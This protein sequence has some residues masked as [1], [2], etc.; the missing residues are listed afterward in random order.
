MSKYGSVAAG[1]QLTAE[2]AYEVLKSG[3]NAFDAAM[4][5][6]FMACVAEPVLASP[7]GGGFLLAKTEKEPV[8]YDFFTQTPRQKIPH[9]T[10]FYPI[11]V[12]FGT[13][14]QEFHIGLGAAAVPGV[15]EGIFKVHGELGTLPASELVKP[16]VAS[17]RNG[18]PVKGIMPYLFKIVSPIYLA[19]QEAKSLFESKESPGKVIGTGDTLK[20]TQLADFLEN[21]ALE[22]P[23]FFYRGPVANAI[24]EDCANEMGHL[25]QK[26]FDSYQVIRRKPLYN[27]YHNA[28]IW[29]NPQP[30][31]GGLLISLGLQLLQPF[32]LKQLSYGSNAYLDLLGKTMA[33]TNAV[34]K[35]S[36]EGPPDSHRDA[37]NAIDPALIK[38][39]Q[40]IQDE[41]PVNPRGTTHISIIDRESQIA[42]MTLSNGEGCGY[43]V[44]NCGFM[45]NNMLGEEDLNPAGFHLWKPN[46]RI[47]SMMAP[48]IINQR[49]RQIATGSGGSNRIRSALLQIIINCVDY[50]MSI[51][52]AVERPRVHFEHGIF[53]LESGFPTASLTHIK[54]Q[55]M[56][57]KI[58]PDSNLFFGG[59]HTVCRDQEGQFSG[60]GDPRR[61]GVCL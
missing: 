31:L 46:T 43:I 12:D 1:H 47:A 2:A 38:A 16:A 21:L 24:Y 9:G 45:L 50:E 8:L 19:S 29:T 11:E 59:A 49:N 53:N 33:I 39:L 55:Y 42:T 3:G 44:P 61:G 28:D 58:W 32:N 56:N 13:V 27:R 10:E 36:I 17:G 7:G 4:A 48:T 5:A 14:V 40:K 20:Q 26:D 54:S 51:Q 37:L 60:M 25:T 52:D 57:T 34:K 22:G 6:F 41:H 35:N 30:S 18:I 15:V 23:D